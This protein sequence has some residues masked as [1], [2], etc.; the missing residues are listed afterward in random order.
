MPLRQ[1]SSDRQLELQPSPDRLLP[2]SQTSAHLVS[3]AVPFKHSLG[4]VV[5][6]LGRWS[7]LT[8]LPQLSSDL[9]SARQLSALTVLPSS[10]ASSS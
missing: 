9:Q 3:R 2:S 10:Q 6:F 8:P 5:R 7:S 1:V 4:L